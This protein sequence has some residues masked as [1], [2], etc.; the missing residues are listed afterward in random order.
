MKFLKDAQE[1]AFSPKDAIVKRLIK[2]IGRYDAAR[3]YDK[4]H[5]SDITSNSFCPRMVAL[6]D[7]TK[8]K[9]KD[10]YLSPALAATFDMGNSV[11]DLF[12]EKW[13]SGWNYGNWQCLRCGEQRTFCLKPQNVMCPKTDH[14]LSC[15]WKYKEVAFVSPQYQVSGSLDAILDLGSP[16]LFVTELKILAQTDFEKI[17][18]PLP[19]HRIR[20]ALYL[21][22]IDD[23]N[24]VY[25][26]RMN[27]QQ[28]KVLYVSRGY[29]KAHPEYG[30]EI[31]PFKEF[32]V[33]RDDASLAPYLE[34]ALTVKNWRENKVIPS[35]V[36][37]S[38]ADPRAKNCA[39]CP[40]CFSGK[41]PA[42]KQ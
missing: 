40:Q 21:K 22:L 16:L 3:P 41:Y 5:A 18:A 6:L 15:Q 23:S 24:S 10:Q 30:K 29:G 14:K 20:T 13:A 28:A 1:K 34:K 42:V 31:L 26:I 36:C 38:S 32:D 4:I 39:V 19:E 17:V 25:K 7:I 8:L 35:G 33:K 11:A 37:G 2:S 27:L 9:K 12:C